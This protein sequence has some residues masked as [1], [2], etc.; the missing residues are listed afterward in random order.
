MRFSRLGII[1]LLSAIVLGLSAC[2]PINSI[3]ARRDL[4]E[5]AKAYKDRNYAEAEK[6]FRS[7]MTLDPNQKQAR[8]FLARTL[9]SEY[10]AD[11][12]QVGK[13][14]EAIGVYKDVLK[15]EP[16]DSSSFKAVASLLET[17]GRKDDA[18]KWLQDRTTQEGVPDDQRAEAYTSLAAKDNT[19]AN[20]ISDIEPV[21]KTVEKG[22]KAEFVFTK[23]ANPDDYEKLKR[24][25]AEGMD[26]IDKALALE[27][28]K[29]TN[30]K[31]VDIKTLNDKDLNELNELVK[32]FE[33][34]WS[35][36]TSLQVQ[37]SRLAEMDGRAADKDDFKKKSDI[38]RQRFLDLAGVRKSL[39]DEKELRR[40]AAED[41]KATM[42]GGG[43][44]NSNANSAK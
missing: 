16:A 20:E 17:M 34:A 13:A 12:A 6:R 3:F 42:K 22:D 31:K 4:I 18:L 39:E 40:K 21:K 15:G 1:I 2:G 44:D 25:I 33:S 14:E 11:R 7:A 37:S 26:Y 29:S 23:P 36:K 32:K 41:E 24:C 28:D 19:C 8:L 27:S 38:S 43:G 10:A 35:Y 9:H 5:G 30:A